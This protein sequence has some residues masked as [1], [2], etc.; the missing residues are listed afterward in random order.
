MD[1]N[2]HPSRKTVHLAMCVS[3]CMQMVFRGRAAGDV[4][5]QRQARF[6]ACPQHTRDCAPSHTAVYFGRD[7]ETALVPFSFSPR[8][9]SRS[10]HF[11][12][13]ACWPPGFSAVPGLL[14]GFMDTYPTK[15]Q[16]KPLIDFQYKFTKQTTLHLSAHLH[17]LLLQLLGILTLKLN[18]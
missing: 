2:A 1:F 11:S 3:C 10:P 15:V 17:F 13:R 4:E 7:G 12:T 14:V 5:Q 8:V 6:P 16:L 9:L 18:G